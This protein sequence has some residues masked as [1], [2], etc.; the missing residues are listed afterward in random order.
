MFISILHL[1]C[2]SACLVVPTE[3]IIYIEDFEWWCWKLHC[4]VF[5]SVFSSI[6][7]IVYFIMFHIHWRFIVL[8]DISLLQLGWYWCHIH[9]PQRCIYSIRNIWMGISCRVWIYSPR[10]FNHAIHYLIFLS[11]IIFFPLQESVL[12]Y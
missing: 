9:T 3:S 11:W 1:H 7:L 12:L 8:C 6:W 4:Q 5:E 2:A 10:K